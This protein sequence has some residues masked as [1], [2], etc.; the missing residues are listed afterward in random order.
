MPRNSAKPAE[1][2][3]LL[4]DRLLVEYSG[5]LPPG[6]VLA[7]VHR[8]NKMLSTGSSTAPRAERLSTLEAV[9]RRL[10]TD[11]IALLGAKRRY[12]DF[13]S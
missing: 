9:V 7:T 11:R 4:A 1:A 10:L 12:A 5:A 2:S 13:G 8:A 6:Q 3:S